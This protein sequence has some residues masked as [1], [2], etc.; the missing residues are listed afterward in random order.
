MHARE[1][2]DKRDYRGHLRQREPEAPW[3]LQTV[4][5][6]RVTR[7]VGVFSAGVALCVQYENK[8]KLLTPV[9]RAKGL[10]ESLAFDPSPPLSQLY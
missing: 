6:V 5:V 8:N 2:R 10:R 4:R 7:F 1:Q 9:V 3:L